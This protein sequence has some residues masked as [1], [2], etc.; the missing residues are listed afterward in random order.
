MKTFIAFVLGVASAI[1]G[2]VADVNALA[3]LGFLTIA[4]TI[5]IGFFKLVA[6]GTEAQHQ[7]DVQKIRDAG[8]TEAEALTYAS[9]ERQ[10]RDSWFQAAAQ[11]KK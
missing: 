6:A 9:L 7:A 11:M 10:R 5:L 2:V 1:I 8:G 3:G 4:V